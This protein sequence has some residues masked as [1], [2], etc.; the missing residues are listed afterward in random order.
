MTTIRDEEQVFRS[1]VLPKPCHPIQ[2]QEMI[3]SFYAGCSS[4][5]KIVFEVAE[6]EDEATRRQRTEELQEEM[7]AF[8]L[9]VE[10][11]QA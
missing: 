5:L 11:G 7:E 2:E 8:A 6:I 1:L 4:M 9:K 3:R 10:R